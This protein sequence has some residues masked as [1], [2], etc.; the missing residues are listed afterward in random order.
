MNAHSLLLALLA[1]LPL[2]SAATPSQAPALL[3]DC[4]RPVLPSQR[5]VAEFAGMANF[6]QAYA[7]RERLMQDVQ[8]ACKRGAGQVRLVREPGTAGTE[9]AVT[10]AAARP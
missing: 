7:L 2:A 4:A 3:V 1:A 5:A 9:P 6:G 8:R 10:V